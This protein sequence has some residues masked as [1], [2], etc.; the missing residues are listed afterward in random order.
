MKK[1]VLFDLYDTVLK[2]ES[3]DFLRGVAYVHEHHLSDVCT[4][5][6]LKAYTD[7]F[8][9]L[10]HQRHV[11]HSEIHFARDE[12]PLWFSHFGKE[13]PRNVDDL[14]YAIMSAMQDG[15]VLDEVRFVLDELRSRDI[16]M[17]ILS[18]TIF[19]AQATKRLLSHHGVLDY[20]EEVYAS[21]DAGVRKP[22]PRFF[23]WAIGHIQRRRPDL[24]REDMLFVGNDYNLDA[25]GGVAAGLDTVWYNVDG[26][27]NEDD[28][29]VIV[30]DNFKD[31]LKWI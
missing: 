23:D 16:P 8:L 14:E 18:N 17:Y 1:A 4:Y 2:N 26:A 27:P 31:V 19:T 9:P 20:F 13:L 10:Y 12:L 25:R 5:E 7:T 3:F 6:E 11:D 28:L 15:G 29:D 21:A 24:G 22:S 30:T